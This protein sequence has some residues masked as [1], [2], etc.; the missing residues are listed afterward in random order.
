MKRP[1]PGV[2]NFVLCFYFFVKLFG[3]STFYYSTRPFQILE[4]SFSKCYAIAYG[5]TLT[6]LLTLQSF[7]ATF[8]HVWRLY[9]STT[10]VQY[11]V[12]LCELWIFAL[13]TIL[14]FICHFHHRRLIIKLLN[15]AIS[16]ILLVNQL[17]LH[18][19]FF[20]Q[21]FARNFKIRL[22]FM[23]SEFF[24]ILIPFCL[25]IIFYEFDII[26]FG[27]FWI[28]LYV[29]N[30]IIINFFIHGVNFVALNLLQIVNKNTTELLANQ[31]ELRKSTIINLEN[32]SVFYARIIRFVK[33]ANV[34]FRFSTVHA[35]L[36]SFI[37]VLSSVSSLNFK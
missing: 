29:T 32:L 6:T 19:N 4:S 10:N 27:L 35:I 21:N 7:I 12:V 22:I 34:I 1:P 20:D 5:I 25:T 23:F 13:G 26:Y 17:T 31:N 18:F 11:T 14:N 15:E 37:A 16:L 30:F 8:S 28:L 33:D 36:L 9:D 24:I 3:L 2:Q